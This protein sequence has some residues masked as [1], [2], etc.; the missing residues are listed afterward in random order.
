MSFC[1]RFELSAQWAAIMLTHWEERILR[2]PSVAQDDTS[3]RYLVR[4]SGQK[5]TPTCHPEQAKRAEGSASPASV[6]CCRPQGATNTNIKQN[7]KLKLKNPAAHE[8]RRRYASSLCLLF[9]FILDLVDGIDGDEGIRVHFF[10][11]VHQYPEFLLVHD[12]VDLPADGLIVGADG[13]I[14]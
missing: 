13:I 9:R 8:K 6:G 1:G 12:N 5:P 2:L 3:F 7:D 11:V 10:D 14:E 4:N